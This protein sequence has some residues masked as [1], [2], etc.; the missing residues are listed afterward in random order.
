MV[1]YAT[2]LTRRKLVVGLLAVC[3]MVVGAGPARPY[4]CGKDTRWEALGFMVMYAT[5]LTR[6]KLVVG[7]LAVCAMVVGAGCWLLGGEADTASTAAEVSISCKLKTN[8]DRVAFLRGYGWEVDENPVSEQDVRIPDTFDAAYQSYNELQ[9]TQGPDTFDAAYQ[10]YN[11]LQKT[12]G[13]DLTHYQGRKCQLYVYQVRNDPSGETGVTANLVLYR[14]NLIAADI[15]SE[16]ADG[17]VRAV[18]DQLY[19]YQVR[20]DPSGET[21]V[22]ANLVLYRD[23][24]I[25]ADICS[26]DADGFVRAVTDRSASD[27]TQT[28]SEGE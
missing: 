28:P 25:A 20:N 8:D 2:K 5:K 26:E 27:Q 16:D 9:K 21:G 10:S 18:T 3:A 1:M 23:N 19:V 14:D 7:L 6:R 24:L 11:E 12:Q 15:C 17:F 13:L 22:T 4:L